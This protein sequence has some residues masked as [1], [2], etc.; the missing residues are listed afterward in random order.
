MRRVDPV[1]PKVIVGKKVRQVGGVEGGDEDREEEV[2]DEEEQENGQ[3]IVV[4]MH[5]PRMPTR[6]EREEHAMTHL[7]FRSW[8]EHCVKGR[9][10]EIRARRSLSRQ[11]C[12]WTFALAF[13]Q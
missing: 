9:G 13:D 10:E 2:Q 11:R 4:K 12:T 5:Q 3:R 7:L 1:R 6:A 8:C